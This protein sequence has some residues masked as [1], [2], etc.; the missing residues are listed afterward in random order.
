VEP[1]SFVV[2]VVVV[3]A[4]KSSSGSIVHCSDA[5]A[6]ERNVVRGC[7]AFCYSDQ[8]GI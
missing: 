1:C 3:D 5:P 6:L 4:S 2:V 7:L 8:H